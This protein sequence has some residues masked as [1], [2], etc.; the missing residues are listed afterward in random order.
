M[1][2]V[3]DGGTAS[4]NQYAAGGAPGALGCSRFA[5][6]P[7]VGD[8]DGDVVFAFCMET[9][10]ITAAESSAAGFWIGGHCGHSA[11]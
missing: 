7:A 5:I 9:G 10:K 8:L 6:D 2:V 4:G 11:C 3:G 1:A